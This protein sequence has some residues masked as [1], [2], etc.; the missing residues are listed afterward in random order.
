MNKSKKFG[1]PAAEVK[2]EVKLDAHAG[3]FKPEGVKEV[4][5]EVTS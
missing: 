3:E 1:V 4:E 5:L 2:K